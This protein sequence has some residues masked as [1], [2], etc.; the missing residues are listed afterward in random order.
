MEPTMAAPFK[1]PMSSARK[2]TA[3][4]WI[5]LESTKM[6]L[7]WADL[8]TIELSLLD[9][10]NP[11]VIAKVVA[12]TEQVIEEN[13]FLFI[14]DYGV[15]LEDL[16]REFDLVQ[17]HHLNIT[18]KEKKE[19]LWDPST[20]VSARFKRATNERQANTAGLSSLLFIPQNSKIFRESR[21]AFDRSWMRSLLFVTIWKK[22]VTRHLLQ[23][24]SLVL[25]LPSDWLWDASIVDSDWP[26][27][28]SGH[29]W[30]FLANMNGEHELKFRL[31][32]RLSD[33][34]VFR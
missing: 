9:S 21:T 30:L 8:H 20:G 7:D 22:S 18:E 13:G 27:S 5:P 34:I 23:L 31:Q 14:T 28:R 24:L 19:L 12:T 10:P 1:P 6:S 15:S 25:E 26:V 4:K 32:H 11:D 2:P 3:P 16:H 29:G 33:A 17:Y